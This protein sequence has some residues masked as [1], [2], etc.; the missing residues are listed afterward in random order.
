MAYYFLN[1]NSENSICSQVAE[2]VSSAEYFSDIPQSALSRLSLT[3]AT[4]YCSGSVTE[5]CPAS[6]SG[7]TCEPLTGDRGRDSSMSFA[8]E[9]RASE[10]AP[11][12]RGGGFID[13]DYYAGFKRVIREVES[14]TVFLENSPVLIRRGLDCV[15]W[16]L[17]EMGYD[18]R[19]GV[20]GGFDAG[21][22]HA[23][24]RIWIL[25]HSKRHQQ[26]RAKSCSWAPGRV[27]TGREPIPWN[28]SWQTALST[29]RGMAD[30]LAR[31]VER[32]DS[33]RNGQIPAVV[34]LAWN[35][36]TDGLTQQ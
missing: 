34:A 27:G 3:V 14:E 23:R 15:L 19:W 35:T 21:A 32:T 8:P 17:A 36:L 30:G 12:A 10:S 29:I 13:Q 6:P 16:D 9:S 2:G 26:S 20:L 22:P 28:T 7:T 33:I 25:G 24:K 4:S 31:S 5:S 18:A 1:D 11:P